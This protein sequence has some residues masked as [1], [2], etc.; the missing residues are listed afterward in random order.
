MLLFTCIFVLW[1]SNSITARLQSGRQSHLK[2]PYS[3][4]K[5]SNYVIIAFVYRPDTTM[6]VYNR[7]NFLSTSL[8]NALANRICCLLPNYTNKQACCRTLILNTPHRKFL[9]D[10][11]VCASKINR[12]ASWNEI[13]DRVGLGFSII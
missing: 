6:L 7:L 10:C 8:S 1:S 2:G 9:R 12:R 11:Q 3:E 13:S 5:V 4:I